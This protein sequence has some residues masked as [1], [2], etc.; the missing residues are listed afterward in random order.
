MKFKLVWGRRNHGLLRAVTGA[1]SLAVLWL[2]ASTVHAAFMTPLLVASFGL[3]TSLLVDI[4]VGLLAVI[5]AAAGLIG[6]LMVPVLTLLPLLGVPMIMVVADAIPAGHAINVKYRVARRTPSKSAKIIRVAGP[7]ILVIGALGYQGWRAAAVLIIPAVLASAWNK[8]AVIASA[9]SGLVFGYGP[10]LIAMMALSLALAGGRA[11]ARPPRR[12]LP[13][14]PGPRIPPRLAWQVIRTD[15]ALAHADHERAARR[16]GRVPLSS[17]KARLAVWTRQALLALEAGRCQDALDTLARL[18]T[19]QLPRF[20]RP[21]RAIRWLLAETYT[22][23]NRSGDA[24]AILT[25]LMSCGKRLGPR[26]LVYYGLALARSHHYQSDDTASA[27]AAE[28][29]A[30]ALQTRGWP[31]ERSQAHLALGQALL[32]CG[33]LTQAAL[34]ADTAG[35]AILMNRWM[36]SLWNDGKNQNKLIRRASGPEGVIFLE[37]TRVEIFSR[38]VRTESPDT[39][40]TDRYTLTDAEQIA[41]LLAAIGQWDLLAELTMLQARAHA[42]RQEYRKALQAAIRALRELDRNRYELTAPRDRATWY[43]RIREALELAVAITSATNDA[44]L[45]AELLEFARVQTLPQLAGQHVGHE[46]A[47]A[48]P[49][50]VTVRGRARLSRYRDPGRPDPVDL[51][52]AA[53]A[54]AGEGAWWLAYWHAGQW[55]YW[56]LVPP[57]GDTHGGKIDASP[58]SDLATALTTLREALPVPVPGETETQLDWRMSRSILAHDP[59]AEHQLAA[60]LAKILLPRPLM[61]ELAGPTQSGRPLPLAIAPAPILSYLPWSAL[62]IPK[63]R[64]HTGGTSRLAQKADW[65]LAPAAGLFRQ[66]ARRPDIEAPAPLKLAVIDTWRDDHL[67]EL[68]GAQKEA[69]RLP[70]SVTI[71]GGGHWTDQ[72]ATKEAVTHA[73]A[74]MTQPATVLF[75]CHAVPAGKNHQPPGGLVLVGTSPGSGPARLTAEDILA[76]AASGAAMPT[77]VI[78][79]ACDTS[80]L[81]SAESGEWL[82]IAPALLS[83]GSRTIATTLFPISDQAYADSPVVQ[84]AVAGKNLRAAVREM[85]VSR[86]RIWESR[87]SPPQSCSPLAWA[88]YATVCAAG[89]YQ[90]LVMNQP[91]AFSARCQRTLRRAAAQA[92]KRRRRIV[93]AGDIFAAYFEQSSLSFSAIALHATI[94]LASRV[95]RSPPAERYSAPS[96]ISPSED[97]VDALAA[98]IS[99]AKREAREIE[100]EDLVLS[101]IQRPSSARRLLRIIT[102]TRA[103]TE[104]QVINSAQHSLA[105][106]LIAQ[107][108]VILRAADPEVQVFLSNIATMVENLSA[109]SSGEHHQPGIANENRTKHRKLGT[110]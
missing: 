14:P 100:P 26:E 97:L 33:L 71:L 52:S 16:L 7:W 60:H 34:Q 6:W 32:G 83:A 102:I 51:E 42:S 47:L 27:K 1:F 107:E 105:N 99:E 95:F 35:L 19:L 63:T 30:E 40:D 48:T 69:S 50:V 75:A 65:V 53:A 87:T 11:L 20:S 44:G 68:S 58:G 18:K 61:A 72:L 106:A 86:S 74:T 70:D 91:P 38:R 54:A 92:R 98:A 66:A 104:K 64:G 28:A 110:L 67:P 59:A 31:L 24:I 2:F 9:V 90:G 81:A 55:L 82:T 25:D 46:W 56:S 79:E 96:G 73:L 76:I 93:T 39:A 94:S 36:R 23:V 89:S 62:L 43:E 109:T 3:E 8:L 29:A 5:L 108:I 45:Q 22:A 17:D 84:A 77:Q 80:D 49:P 12:H 37:W 21:E 88:S 10:F 78:L 41:D 85:Q 101:S 4:A 103:Q 15:Q 57:V 13:L